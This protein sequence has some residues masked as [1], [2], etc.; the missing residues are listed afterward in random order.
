VN[1]LPINA[2]RHGAAR[3]FVSLVFFEGG[4]AAKKQRDAGGAG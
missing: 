2:A 1:G 4:N 3:R